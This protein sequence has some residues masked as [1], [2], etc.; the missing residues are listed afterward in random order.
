MLED[1]VELALSPDAEEDAAGED[2]EVDGEEADVDGV[3]SEDED[4]AVDGVLTA[5]LAPS[6]AVVVEFV[7]VV[8]DVTCCCCGVC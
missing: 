5:P 8:V 4:A 3:V 7:D 6:V 2:V 1:A